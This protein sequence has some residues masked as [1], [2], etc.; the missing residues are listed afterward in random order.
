MPSRAFRSARQHLIRTDTNVR[1]AVRQAVFEAADEL[2]DKAETAVSD[3]KHKPRFQVQRVIT[4]SM[5]SVTIS[6]AGRN[7]T[8]FNYVDQGTKG[9]YRIPKFIRPETQTAKPVLLKFRT[10][11]N[12]RTA[13]V[14][15]HHQG[16][17]RASGAWVSKRQVTH[18]GIRARKF[19]TTFEEEL[20][21][22]LNRRV[23]NGIRRAVR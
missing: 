17:G 19:L 3:W 8:I 21:P 9:P 5:I 16:S 14:A 18:P 6:P 10:G 12:A 2:N 23:D 11:Y 20:R 4:P 22:S 1:R 13:P 7:A 15:K